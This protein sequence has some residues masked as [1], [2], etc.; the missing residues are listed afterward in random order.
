MTTISFRSNIAGK[1]LDKKSNNR[2]KRK[3]SSL[4][5]KSSQDYFKVADYMANINKIIT[6]SSN[7]NFTGIASKH[8]VK[9][10]IGFGGELNKTALKKLTKN[11]KSRSPDIQ[12]TVL[13]DLER[14]D[15]K[16]IEPE[17][18]PKMVELFKILSNGEDFKVKTALAESLTKMADKGLDEKIAIESIEILKDM[19]TFNDEDLRISIAKNLEKLGTSNKK[20]AP[21]AVDA[22]ETM[23]IDK[24]FRIRV[25]LAASKKR[26]T[27]KELT[28]GLTEAIKQ[29]KKFG[30][31]GRIRVFTDEGF[32][33]REIVAES[34]ALIGIV[35]KELAPKI[36][37]ILKSMVTNE[38]SIGKDS[39]EKT[40]ERLGIKEL[41]Q[42]IFYDNRKKDNNVEITAIKSL[43]SIGVAH[44]FM[45]SRIIKALNPLTLS[46]N[47][48][49]KKNAHISINI[50]DNIAKEKIVEKEKEK[51]KEEIAKKRKFQEIKNIWNKKINSLLYTIIPEPAYINNFYILNNGRYLN[52]QKFMSY[53]PNS[54]KRIKKLEK[55]SSDMLKIG[56]L[57]DK[58]V[59]NT[60]QSLALGLDQSTQSSNTKFTTYWL[61]NKNL[62]NKNLT[63]FWLNAL[64]KNSKTMTPEKKLAK[65]NELSKFDKCRLI[66]T[67]ANEYVQNVL[68]VELN[69][70]NNS[71]IEELEE[72]ESFN[73]D[74]IKNLLQ[75]GEYQNK[76]IADKNILDFW[77]DVIEGEGQSNEYLTQRMKQGK[78][79]ELIADENNADKIV[80][81]TIKASRKTNTLVQTAQKAYKD[82]I[83]ND[84][85]FNE[86][87]KSLLKDYQ[88]SKLFFYVVTDKVK[89]QN[90]I[91]K[92]QGNTFK[93]TKEL[94]NEK[95]TTRE[96]SDA[97]VFSPLKDYKAIFGNI[98]DTKISSKVDFIFKLLSNKI[99]LSNQLEA[100]RTK[101]KL[102]LFKRA[103]ACNSYNAE[104]AW[105]RLLKEA[106]EFYNIE[107]LNKITNKNI[108][109]LHSM[110]TKLST[111]NNETV[112][113]AIND[114]SL[115][116]I[117][118]KDFI[119]R[120]KDD[121]NFKM[122]LSNNAIL[123]KEAIDLLLSFEDNNK[124]M[125]KL[126]SQS[127]KENI[128]PEII[129]ENKDLANRYI[130]A[131][132][133]DTVVMK[134]DE[135]KFNFLNSIPKE[136]LELVSHKVS[137][138]WK[139]GT[140]KKFMSKKF[141]EIELQH[142]INAHIMNI[143]D[144]LKRVNT[145]LD[146]ISINTDG[147]N[148]TLE[149]ISNNIDK[150]IE[151][152]KDNEAI[153]ID[154]LKGIKEN[155][156]SIQAN[157]RAL[158]LNA[159]NSTGDEE[160]REE[161][162]KLLKDSEQDSLQDFYERIDKKAKKEK[163][164]AIIKL[165]ACAIAAAG[166]AAVFP[167]AVGAIALAGV[168]PTLID[169]IQGKAF[170]KAFND[171]IK[172]GK[173]LVSEM[174]DIVKNASNKPAKA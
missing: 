108:K 126:I 15:L 59:F 134:T 123:K 158:L 174:F 159:M 12:M 168:G 143:N 86:A 130:T 57:Y 53:H 63:D 30:P 144:A 43:E 148:Q 44:E 84:P 2:E 170:A 163:W 101:Y 111:E 65:I 19:V 58:F 105:I 133:K 87:Q 140:L 167:P 28:P 96:K 47:D 26:A 129:K 39:V 50:L 36:V 70:L 135:E 7:L 92:I 110:N 151:H 61:T 171:G 67:T 142:N 45:S 69:R 31:D 38:Y 79:E 153:K 156:L 109:K 89:S 85:D 125:F 64:G 11:A 100:G 54:A 60:L 14:Y 51:E 10:F 114:I 147:Q 128:N 116:S 146:K 23:A 112:L 42:I 52:I 166:A 121:I 73:K 97:E 33:T 6:K 72:S 120:Y 91:F 132:G 119:V 46:S 17:M 74:T 13:R 75:T 82:I 4:Y 149:N 152:Y 150:Y 161:I 81:E 41:A 117:K 37:K 102:R 1:N 90:D 145:F 94:V 131:L 162:E 3:S 154:Q 48:I 77:I 104:S 62:G 173:Q 137:K 118:Q 113:N 83:D 56:Q 172:G 136:E 71:D 138:D 127:F 25:S 80:E 88:N 5:K 22:L 160:L 169:A 27:D 98:D 18:T 32:K 139:E 24:D 122:I 66:I 9:K 68:P 8:I 76:K 49:I 29:C 20:L 40:L 55:N 93:V 141:L 155:S 164:K 34:L 99:E 35:H 124:S 21:R 78:V 103:I 95:S 157:T 115:E 165:L 16:T 106:Q 107:I